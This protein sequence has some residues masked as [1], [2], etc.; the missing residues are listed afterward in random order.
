MEEIIPRK[1]SAALV[2]ANP[3]IESCQV[4]RSFTPTSQLIHLV[5]L[6]TKEMDRREVGPG[7]TLDAPA[8]AK[9]PGRVEASRRIVRPESSAVLPPGLV[10]DRAIN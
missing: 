8:S 2:E 4:L 10:S 6:A 1:S 3:S 9:V 7:R 5:D